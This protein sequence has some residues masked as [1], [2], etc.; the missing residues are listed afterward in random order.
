MARAV[1]VS[2]AAERRA[3]SAAARL[4]PMTPYSHSDVAAGDRAGRFSLSPEKSLS[5]VSTSQKRQIGELGL[6]PLPQ[7]ERFRSKKSAIQAQPLPL[8]LLKK[9]QLH[10]LLWPVQ[11]NRYLQAKSST[12][13]STLLKAYTLYLVPYMVSN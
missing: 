13:V 5:V 1:G 8:S 3:V 6:L 7:R 10:F 9:Q 11:N 2:S 12:M 4:L